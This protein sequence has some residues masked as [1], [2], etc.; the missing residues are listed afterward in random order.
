MM[1]L[2]KFKMSED[3][4]C[5]NFFIESGKSEYDANFGFASVFE[6]Y[7]LSR[8]WNLSILFEAS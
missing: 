8:L 6:L 1:Y 2:I 4:W 5:V 3:L 7:G